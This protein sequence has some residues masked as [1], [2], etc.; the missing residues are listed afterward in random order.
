MNIFSAVFGSI[1][2]SLFG[3]NHI[4]N[5]E[6]NPIVNVDGTAMVGDFDTN[7]NPYGVTSTFDSIGMSESVNDFH[8]DHDSMFSCSSSSSSFDN[9]FSSFS[10]DNSFSSGG[11][12]DD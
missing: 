12:F 9:S 10:D 6:S 7:G 3:S 11:C 8:S 2:D 1:G 5:V 4:N